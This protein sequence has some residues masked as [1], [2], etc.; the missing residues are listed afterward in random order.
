MVGQA[1]DGPAAGGV[2]G[3][4][5][6]HQRDTLLIHGHA[7]NLTT[8]LIAATNIDI[9]QRRGE[10]LFV[11][12]TPTRLRKTLQGTTTA[13]AGQRI[14]V[15]VVSALGSQECWLGG[16]VMAILGEVRQR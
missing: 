3:E 13:I 12:L 9:P 15:D 16:Y 5:Q 1:T 11:R 8:L 14:G 2:L 6:T 7:T 4:G 10:P